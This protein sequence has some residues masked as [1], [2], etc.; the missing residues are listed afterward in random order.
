MLGAYVNLYMAVSSESEKQTGSVDLLLSTEVHD[1][2]E[3]ELMYA[4]EAGNAQVAPKDK[5]IVHSKRY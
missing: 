5:E 1:S 3:V 2:D 4:C